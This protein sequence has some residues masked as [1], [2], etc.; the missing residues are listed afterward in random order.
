MINY[1]L[2][3]AKWIVAQ[4][5]WLEKEVRNP[6]TGNIVKVKSLSP[7][8]QEKY[9]P[10][11]DVSKEKDKLKSD[12]LKKRLKAVNSKISLPKAKSLTKKSLEDIKKSKGVS[13]ISEPRLNQ[14]QTRTSWYERLTYDVTT[15]EKDYNDK[16]KVVEVHV[17]VTDDP[18]SNTKAGDVSIDWSPSRLY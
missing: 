13:S 1:I 12:I 14:R 9:R 17:A 5:D 10:K 7:E 4:E 2:K 3:E 6:A 11:K 16:P 18:S 15:K 8:E